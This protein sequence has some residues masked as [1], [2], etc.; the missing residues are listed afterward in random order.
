MM[1]NQRAT[2]SSTFQP[3]QTAQSSVES[4]L[5][6]DIIKE[7]SQILSDLMDQFLQ[8]HP[9]SKFESEFNLFARRI[10][11]ITR[12]EQ[13]NGTYRHTIQ[14]PSENDTPTEDDASRENNR[15][16]IESFNIFQQ[17]RPTT[18][19]HKP[20]TTLTHN[21]QLKNIHCTSN[22][23]CDTIIKESIINNS[24]TQENRQQSEFLPPTAPIPYSE[25]LQI[26]DTLPT[27]SNNANADSVMESDAEVFESFKTPSNS[28]NTSTSQLNQDQS[29][30]SERS[31]E[32][33]KFKYLT[34]W[35]VNLKEI[36]SNKGNSKSVITLTG[37]LLARDQITKLKKVHKAGVLVARKSKNIINTDKG[38]YHLIG[39]IAE[40][41]PLKLFRACIETNG[42]PK[43]WRKILMHLTTEVEVNLN[44][45]V[46]RKGTIYN[47]EKKASHN[48]PETEE[49]PEEDLPCNLLNDSDFCQQL[50]QL[51]TPKITKSFGGCQTPSALLKHKFHRKFVK[52]CLIIGSLEDSEEQ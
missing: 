12:D 6:N 25:S 46:T 51:S 23:S 22:N 33:I 30:C 3:Q 2:S 16:H 17:Y 27:T 36:K 35:S 15:Q 49:F 13:R 18:T 26:N 9:F 52:A 50:L 34:N 20:K 28:E 11:H 40:G 21:D 48:V 38:Y 43:T 5:F 45:S 37:T 31:D 1:N 7:K 44:E 42:I 14:T 4:L 8:V 19:N 29:N 39:P 32:R 41:S 47:K 10:K 24:S